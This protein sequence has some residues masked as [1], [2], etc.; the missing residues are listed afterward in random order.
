MVTMK[1]ICSISKKIN[2]SL[3]K[4]NKELTQ[5]VNT[6]LQEIRK[7]DKILFQQ[8]KLAAMTEM[9]SAVAH[10]WKQPLSIISTHISALP[11]YAKG[12]VVPLKN[13]EITTNEILKQVDHLTQTLDHFRK[14]FNTDF[15][16]ET[17]RLKG[18]IKESLE[19]MEKDLEYHNIDI[20][21][22]F[23]DTLKVDLIESEFKHIIINLVN[24]SKDAFLEHK[25]KNKYIR[26]SV[27]ESQEYTILKVCDN[28][29]GVPLDIIQKVFNANF[30][31]KSK[32]KGSGIG[33]YMSKL[34]IEKIHGKI[35]VANSK[36][37]ACF[38]IFIPKI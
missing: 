22:D 9:M 1:E 35:T 14:F 33:L 5:I 29:Q 6:Q 20:I 32:D 37:G 3:E 24:N 12:E 34:I 25:I 27:L 11:L 2:R 17:I 28:A 30:T 19:L 10:Q 18:L 13:V 31:T 4:T 7:K 23:D 38:E 36:D 16:I 26:F 8:A 15:K 21:L